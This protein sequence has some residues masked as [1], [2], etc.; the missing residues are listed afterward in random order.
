[1]TNV[2]VAELLRQMA[3]ALEVKGEEFFR[4]KAYENAATSIEHT[5]TDLKDLW[6]E[7][8]LDSVAGLGPN[9]IGHLDEL[10]KT[11]KVKHFETEFKSL[12]EGMFELL[13]LP[14]IGPKTAYKLAKA[15]KLTEAK[16]AREKL[17]KAAEKGEI[18]KLEGFGVDSQ[19]KI[20]NALTTKLPDQGRMLLP[21]AEGLASEVR[22]YLRDCVAAEEVEVL[23]SLR[24]RSSTVGDV[25]MAVKTD[26]PVKVIEY[27]KQFGGIKKILGAGEIQISFLHKSGRRIDIKTQSREAWGSVLQHYT[28]SKLH[29]I[30][31]RKIAL[32]KGWSL[33][34]NGI[35][36]VKGQRLKV[37][38][39][40]T[41]ETEKTFYE[42]L[43]MEWIPA[44]LREDRGEIEAAQK[45]QLP[46]LVELSQIKGDLHLHSS[47]EIAT[48]HD[49]GE[50]SVSE[51]MAEAERLGYEYVGIADHNPRLK[52]LTVAEREKLISR[53]NRQIEQEIYSYEKG[54]KRNSR[55][56]VLKGMEVDIR[57]DGDLALSDN[58]LMSLDYVI[59]SIHSVFDQDKKTAT[60][61]ILKALNH[62]KVK[63]WGHPSGRLIQQRQ[64]LDYDWERVFDF[65]KKRGILVEINAWPRRLDLS[66]DLIRVAIKSG[67]KMI[68][69]TDSHK[70]EQMKLIEYGVNNARRGWAEAKDIANTLPWEEFEKLL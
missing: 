7:E 29:N 1:M 13:N 35:K 41:F 25:D 24:R 60:E 38:G 57:P 26:S 12:P 44:E 4:F 61:R 30:H 32:E 52:E 59:V 6:E 33:S 2:E 49:E 22:E 62:P 48:S 20:I 27:L 10:F 51:I 17:L 50:N 55:V 37:Q 14:S 31:L 15:F 66:E 11:G 67:V 42:A 65:C 34:E 40:R 23:G 68:I 45:R 58:L 16:T 19:T 21:E 43:G 69:N 46:K 9:L 36:Q 28:G 47:I 18:D 5:T 56:K 3:A 63:I 53:R 8:Q 39:T 64:G 54:V 70:V